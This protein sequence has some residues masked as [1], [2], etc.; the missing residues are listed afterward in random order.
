MMVES[1]GGKGHR[2]PEQ[3][4]VEVYTA[5]DLQ[6]AD[7]VAQHCQ[8]AGSVEVQRLPLRL[9]EL[10]SYRDTVLVPGGCAV[11]CGED[12]MAQGVSSKNLCA[13]LDPFVEPFQE[14]DRKSVAQVP[15]TGLVKDGVVGQSLFEP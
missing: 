3:R 8:F 6:F 1:A 14:C 11:G 13:S 5:I 9:T 10:R 12:I 2:I 15:V 7:V 4:E